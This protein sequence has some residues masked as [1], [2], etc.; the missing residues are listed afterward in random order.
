MNEKHFLY[1]SLSF[2]TLHIDESVFAFI[3]GRNLGNF[4]RIKEEQFTHHLY[5]IMV[6]LCINIIWVWGIVYLILVSQNL[7]QINE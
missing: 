5:D 1:L 4:N 2:G 3:L 6:H 7:S